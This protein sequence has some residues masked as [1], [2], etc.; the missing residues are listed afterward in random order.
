MFD[1]VMPTFNSNPTY[2]REALD[3][4][5]AQDY[6]DWHLYVCD[7]TPADGK[8]PP[9]LD[10]LKDYN[11]QKWTYLEQTGKGVSQG[12]NQAIMAGSNKWVCM[13]DSDDVWVTDRLSQALIA[14]KDEPNISWAG[15]IVDIQIVSAKGNTF[16]STRRIG[17]LPFWDY[18]REEHRWIR[19]H[20]NPISTSTV[21]V[22]RPLF[23][24]HLFR[25][26][27]N[28]G[29]DTELWCRIIREDQQKVYQH[30]SIVAKYR[31]H[32]DQTTALGVSTTL[33]REQLEVQA[34]A[35]DRLTTQD[36]MA[37]ARRFSEGKTVP[38]EYWKWFEHQVTIR[39]VRLDNNQQISVKGHNNSEVV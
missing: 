13:M 3:S 5:F 34:T 11:P 19:V 23:D 27:M 24:L 12:R 28:Y 39:D 15:A 7:G 20:M 35:G 2:L 32:S 10:T 18:T 9:A 30:E 8:Y 14:L 16:N 25:E 36:F 31:A 4:L 1:V 29:E 6:D 38:D 26:D 33:T 17:L 37:E 22:H 21:I